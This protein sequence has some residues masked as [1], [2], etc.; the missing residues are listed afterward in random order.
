MNLCLSLFFFFNREALNKF[1]SYNYDLLA[2][3]NMQ[4]RLKP[5]KVYR[6]PDTRWQNS[7][8]LGWK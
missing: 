3:K 8:Y 1:L 4:T 7:C 5:L 6:V 2:V